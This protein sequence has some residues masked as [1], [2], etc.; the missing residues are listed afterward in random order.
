ML[1]FSLDELNDSM[2]LKQEEIVYILTIQTENYAW[3]HVIP[4]SCYSQCH[5]PEVYH[6]I[7]SLIFSEGF[8]FIVHY[9]F[10]S[11]PSD[12]FF[13]IGKS[14]TPFLREDKKIS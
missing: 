5:Q 2:E 9:L 14:L 3:Y 12:F 10:S 8:S 11:L 4:L 1:I 7:S 6:N 13:F